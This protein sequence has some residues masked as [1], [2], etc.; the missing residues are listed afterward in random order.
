[1]SDPTPID[2]AALAAP[3]PPADIEWRQQGKVS[4]RGSAMLLPYITSRA[5]M[6]R[7]DDVL[8]PAG[9]YDAYTAGPQGGVVCT[10]TVRVGDGWVSKQ[11]GAENTD[12]DG[13]KGGISSALK[14]AAVKW[15][16]GRYLYALPQFWAEWKQ[17][18]APRGAN[19]ARAKKGQ[20]WGYCIA[21]SLPQWALPPATKREKPH[22]AQ[23]RRGA[24]DG[25][26][27]G[28]GQAA[29]FAA[30][31]RLEVAPT[32]DAIKAWCIAHERP[33]PST[34]RRD[35]RDKL[36]TWLEGTG[37]GVVL[38]WEHAQAER[39]AIQAE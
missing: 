23:V 11:D 31:G 28:G 33:K 36:V 3:F 18:Y 26:W 34:M 19:H 38:D 17:G 32:Y 8:T 25:D 2:W 29:F 15:G 5:V 16:I 22:E 1:M 9:W 21:P 39:K 12:I 27:E 14:R 35:Q 6:A 13:V 4:G 24:H 37:A 20:E 7:L 30:I 10:L